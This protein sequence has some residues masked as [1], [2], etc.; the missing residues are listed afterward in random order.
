LLTGAPIPYTGPWSTQAKRFSNSTNVIAF[1]NLAVK[2]FG[3]FRRL[4][5][6][7]KDSARR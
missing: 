5:L 4:A 3:D 2:V 6:A 7:V 1:E